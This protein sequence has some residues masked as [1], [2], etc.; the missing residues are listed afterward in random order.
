MEI[1][2]YGANCVRLVDKKISLVVDDNLESLGLKSVTKSD[3]IS[4]FTIDKDANKS[5]GR[6]LINGPGEYEISG[7][8]IR[9]VAAQA[10]IDSD[11]LRATMYSLEIQG[12]TIGILGHIHPD[13]S[14]DQLEYLGLLDVLIVPVGGNGYTLDA[15]GATQLIKKI[16]PKVVIPTHYADEAIKYEVPQAELQVFLKEMGI[17]EPEE[18]SVFKVKETEFGDK[19]RVVVLNRES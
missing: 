6:F 12:F 19:T 3:D 14:D 2:F 11:G 10:H 5:V 15:N 16:E 9:G 17:S 1:H 13:L 4:L 7:E 8:S 18:M